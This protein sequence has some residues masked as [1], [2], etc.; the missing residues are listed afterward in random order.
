MDSYLPS[1]EFRKPN[2]ITKPDIRSTQMGIS[3]VEY[4]HKLIQDYELHEHVP[5]KIRFQFDTVRN[6][7]LHAYYVYRFYPIVKHQLYVTLEH[8]I[9]ECIGSDSLDKYRKSLNKSLPKDVPKYSRGLKLNLKYLVEHELIHNEDFEVWRRG[10]KQ[11]AEGKYRAKILSKMRDCNLS[12]YQWN[13]ADIDYEGVQYDYDYTADIL[14]LIP[15]IRNFFAHGQSDLRPTP[16]VDFEVVS[17]I[18]NNIF[19]RNTLTYQATEAD[20]K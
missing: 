13:D 18:I 1:E 5:E 3:S 6:L 9:N 11:A 12:E 20:T 8:A 2:D 16:M 14:E 10:K 15:K 4:F 7:F 17:V 19:E